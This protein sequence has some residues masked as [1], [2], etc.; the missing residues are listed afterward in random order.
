MGRAVATGRPW[1][2][3]QYPFFLVEHL[4]RGS[5]RRPVALLVRWCLNYPLEIEPAGL[6]R[7][8][9]PSS[10]LV[11][12]DWSLRAERRDQEVCLP[13]PHQS[14]LPQIDQLP[15]LLFSLLSGCLGYDGT[16]LFIYQDNLARY[17]RG[18]PMILARK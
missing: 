13:A 4:G 2:Y 11:P 1:C 16:W 17:K 9:V 10:A 8:S 7:E 12:I 3:W 14:P 15:S 5:S 18:F 6:L